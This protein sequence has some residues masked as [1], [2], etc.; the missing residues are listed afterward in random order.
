MCYINVI[1]NEETI[2]FCQSKLKSFIRNQY[3]IIGETDSKIQSVYMNV[4]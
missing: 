1:I 4:W 3:E 2:F